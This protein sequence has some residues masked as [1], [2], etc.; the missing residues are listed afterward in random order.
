MD[1]RVINAD[2]GK[3]LLDH[4]D[5]LAGNS[6]NVF[7]TDVSGIFSKLRLTSV[8]YRDSL[9]PGITLGFTLGLSH[10]HPPGG[11]HKELVIAM[12]SND[13]LWGLACAS[14]ANKAKEFCP[15]TPGDTLN[16]GTQISKSSQMTGFLIARPILFSE[17]DT[18]IDTK[19]RTVELVQLIPIYHEEIHH[20]LHPGKEAEFLAH[21]SKE[22]LL[23][24]ARKKFLQ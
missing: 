18:V 1:K 24:P 21:F 14:I 6:K 22:E 8:L 2:P 9:E 23:N 7:Y 11:A 10:Y 20:L 15:F 13:E 5:R 4:Y 19:I 3:I 16:F 17:Q 12:R